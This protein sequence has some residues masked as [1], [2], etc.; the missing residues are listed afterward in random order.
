MPPLSQN[1]GM[2]VLEDMLYGGVDPLCNP[3]PD[4]VAGNRFN[5]RRKCV[6]GVST[7]IPKPACHCFNINYEKD[8][9]QL[10]VKHV[11]QSH[12]V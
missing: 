7:L 4:K 9:D 8:N 11:H 5:S 1:I 3:I 6:S 12:C 2:E 10:P